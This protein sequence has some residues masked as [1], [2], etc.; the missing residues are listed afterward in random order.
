[1]DTNNMEPVAIWLQSLGL[2]F[3]ACEPLTFDCR[4]SE[5]EQKALMQDIE[6]HTY[7]CADVK[8]DMENERRPKTW[9]EWNDMRKTYVVEESSVGLEPID[10]RDFGNVLTKIFNGMG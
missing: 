4:R 3:R 10:T 9:D 2:L 7:Y 8:E 6:S 1:M 5:K